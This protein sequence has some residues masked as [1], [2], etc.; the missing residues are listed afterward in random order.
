MIVAERRIRKLGK[1]FIARSH[2]A[3]IEAHKRSRDSGHPVVISENG[4]IYKL[5]PDGQRELLKHLEASTPVR[6]GQKVRIH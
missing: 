5:F 6:M 3:F 1:Q 2:E 4:A